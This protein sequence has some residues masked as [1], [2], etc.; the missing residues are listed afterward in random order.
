MRGCTWSQVESGDGRLMRD[1][2]L[3]SQALP[4]TGGSLMRVWDPPLTSGCR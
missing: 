4:T 2:D 1:G 3:M